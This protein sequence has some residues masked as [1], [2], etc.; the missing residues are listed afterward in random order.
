MD[1]KHLPAAPYLTYLVVRSDVFNLLNAGHC[2]FIP[3]LE[4][5]G[6]HGKSNLTQ[7]AFTLFSE[8]LWKVGYPTK[9]P[10]QSSAVLSW[11]YR[12]LPN[13]ECMNLLSSRAVTQDLA[14]LFGI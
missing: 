12:A 14:V 7:E 1:R 4:S 10:T 2:P 8:G 6:M 13:E 9:P 3:N 11:L 5:Q